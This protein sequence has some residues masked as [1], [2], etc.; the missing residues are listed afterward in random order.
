MKKRIRKFE[1]PREFPHDPRFSYTPEPSCIPE[2]PYPPNTP[3]DI[4][5]G[6]EE[7]EISEKEEDFEGYHKE[8]PQLGEMLKY[9][10]Q[11]SF[12]NQNNP[13]IQNFQ[14][15]PFVYE[16]DQKLEK[17]EIS[18][19]EEESK[20]EV[21]PKRDD[22][23]QDDQIPHEEPP[24]KEQIP[25]EEEPIELVIKGIRNPGFDCFMISSLQ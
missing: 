23:I 5:H 21:S 3:K 25:C 20:E 16:N 8:D 15:S 10:D 9:R 1:E 18:F 13:Q 14:E 22:D 12:Q 4:V 7:S 6:E 17:N 24:Q 11:T 2:P 19:D